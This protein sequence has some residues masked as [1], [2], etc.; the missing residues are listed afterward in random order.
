M[1]YLFDIW[2]LPRHQIA[3]A[4]DW[5]TWV[6]L[7]GRGSGKTRAGAEWVRSQVEGATPDAPGR[8]KHVALIGETLDQA[9]EVMVFGESGLLRCSPPDRM[10]QWQATRR[11]LVWPNGAVAQLFSAHDPESLR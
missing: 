2:A 5:K 3:P 8:A 7:G 9:R 1:P 6:I 11:R 10:P 4:G